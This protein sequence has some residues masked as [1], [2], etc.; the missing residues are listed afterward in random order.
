MVSFVYRRVVGDRLDP[1]G[2][3]RHGPVYRVLYD[4]VYRR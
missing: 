3:A 2:A 1:A 4:K